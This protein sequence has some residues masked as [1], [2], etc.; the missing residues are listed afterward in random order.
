MSLGTQGPG[1]L[2]R[3]RGERWWVPAM[4]KVG[5]SCE[6]KM[7]FKARCLFG[8]SV[9]PA[10]KWGSASARVWG[11]HPADAARRDPVWSPQ[12][13]EWGA[14]PREEPGRLEA[15]PPRRPQG[16]VDSSADLLLMLDSTS[17]R[18]GFHF[19][20]EGQALSCHL[21]GPQSKAQARLRPGRRTRAGRAALRPGRG[22]SLT[23][24]RQGCVRTR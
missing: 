18:L 3:G 4:G 24:R 10:V 17:Q 15:S 13:W 12:R 22:E 8:T 23:Q 6:I 19:P 1:V 2:G 20:P 9:S 11:V 14:R 7:A 5:V 21:D 16:G